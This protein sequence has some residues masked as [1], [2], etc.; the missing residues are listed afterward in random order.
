VYA[1]LATNKPQLD[2]CV[3]HALQA[4]RA[5]QTKAPARHVPRVTIP[6]VDSNARNVPPGRTARQKAKPQCSVQ[7]AITVLQVPLHKRH[8]QALTCTAG[9]ARL[10]RRL[11]HSEA[12]AELLPPLNRAQQDTY[13]HWGISGSAWTEAIAHRAPVWK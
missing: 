10:P 13:V 7:L 1:T 3:L 9:L 2:P 12:T 8:A 5:T 6:W 11:A 4:K